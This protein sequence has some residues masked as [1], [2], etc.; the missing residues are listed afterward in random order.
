MNNTDFSD[1]IKKIKEDCRLFGISKN[2]LAEPLRKNGYKVTVTKGDGEDAK[3][4]RE[5]SVS[6]EEVVA[7]GRVS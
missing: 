7:E 3:I 2:H 5:Y 4:V 1:A 6:S